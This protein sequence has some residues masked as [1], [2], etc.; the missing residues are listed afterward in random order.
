[1]VGGGCAGGGVPPWPLSALPWWGEVSLRAHQWFRSHKYTRIHALGGGPRVALGAVY[2][3]GLY[4]IL[5]YQYCMV[6]SIHT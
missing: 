2:P 6:Y 4:T 1:M 3:L 5:L